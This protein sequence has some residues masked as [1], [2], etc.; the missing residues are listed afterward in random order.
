MNFHLH[1]KLRSA[2]WRHADENQ[3]Q[4]MIMDAEATLLE[5]KKRPRSGEGPATPGSEPPE[6]EEY[7]EDAVGVPI[8]HVTGF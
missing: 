1:V 5:P 8:F 3:N 4:R 2:A 7:E 6:E